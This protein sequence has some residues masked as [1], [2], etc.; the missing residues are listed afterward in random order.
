MG[1]GPA[2]PGAPSCATV[3][4]APGAAELLEPAA[5]T[6]AVLLESA[7]LPLQTAPALS[8]GFT[9]DPP[10]LSERFDAC[11]NRTGC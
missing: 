3:P 7:I 11:P 8:V 1:L 2:G 9:G 10:L 5:P 6:A 4:A